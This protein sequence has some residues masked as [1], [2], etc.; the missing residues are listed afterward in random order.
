MAIPDYQTFMLPLL[1]LG[2]DGEP[3]AIHRAV[4]SLSDRF[5]LRAASLQVV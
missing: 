4:T 1:E 5:R 2:A 3:H